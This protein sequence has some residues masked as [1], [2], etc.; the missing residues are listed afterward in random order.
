MPVAGVPRNPLGQQPDRARRLRV[1]FVARAGQTPAT[2]PYTDDVQD[3]APGSIR[4]VWRQAVNLILP[5]DP[6]AWST[7]NG[8]GHVTRALRYKISST[9]RGAGSDNTRYGR[10]R[11]ITPARHRMLPPTVTAGNKRNQPT[12]RNRLAS[13][14]RRVPTLNEP[15]RPR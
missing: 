11:R 7:N 15:L 5:A 4:R 3:V 14:G 6:I 8:Q 9:Y 2:Q 13:F 10:P 1:A 12:V